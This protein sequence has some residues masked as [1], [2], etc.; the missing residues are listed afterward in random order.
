MRIYPMTIVVSAH[1]SCCYNYV[2]SL[3]HDR[4]SPYIERFHVFTAYPKVLGQQISI[5]TQY[6][7]GNFLSA[8]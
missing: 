7:S 4:G 6:S 5:Q 3:L 8:F 2:P 1:P